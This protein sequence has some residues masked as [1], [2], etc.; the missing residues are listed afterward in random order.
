[1]S[2]RCS[3]NYFNGN[4]MKLIEFYHSLIHVYVQANKN[5]LEYTV[6]LFS[7]VLIFLLRLQKMMGIMSA[8]MEKMGS[9]AIFKGGASKLVWSFLFL[10]I[11]A[12][13]LI[14]LM[15]ISH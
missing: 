2:R 4:R 13:Y 7:R 1:M 6:I 12:A 8:V 9:N 14:S 3:E 11:T 5:L 10:F 15:L